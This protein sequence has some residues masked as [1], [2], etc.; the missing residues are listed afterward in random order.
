M[1]AI[2]AAIRAAGFAVATGERNPDL[3]TGRGGGGH[4]A[5]INAVSPGTEIQ[6]E[7][8]ARMPS[9]PEAARL[10]I[11]EGPGAPR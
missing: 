4:I 7:I 3:L 10:V 9:S 11:P 8:T 5:R 2:S 6:E 1:L